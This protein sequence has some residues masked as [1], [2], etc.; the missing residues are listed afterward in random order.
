MPSLKKSRGPSPAGTRTAASKRQIRKEIWCTLDQS[1]GHVR[2]VQRSSES[3]LM[4]G[5]WELPQAT[6]KPRPAADLPPW[7]TFRHSITVTNYTVHVLRDQRAGRGQ[8]IPI[9]DLPQLP[10][11]G[12]TRKILR[13]AG[14][15]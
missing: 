10:L 4:P 12:L 5:M 14:I 2:L 11:T 13:A 3:S 6:E 8:R 1:D 15:I 9:S 7:R